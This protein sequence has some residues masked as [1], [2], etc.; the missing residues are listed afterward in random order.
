M[1]YLRLV[2]VASRKAAGVKRLARGHRERPRRE[3]AVGRH[4]VGQVGLENDDP[5]RPF[6]LADAGRRAAGR[7][8]GFD[9]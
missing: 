5:S 3:V 8:R 2:P 7:A 6:Q 9:Q 4:R 1:T